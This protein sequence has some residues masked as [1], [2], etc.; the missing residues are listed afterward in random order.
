[1][2]QMLVFEKKKNCKNNCIF[3]LFNHL[4]IIIIINNND[5][6]LL[7][8][9]TTWKSALITRFCKINSGTRV[10]VMHMANKFFYIWKLV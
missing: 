8:K 10:S 2:V 4:K 9:K 3:I 5:H 1:M 6:K 7:N